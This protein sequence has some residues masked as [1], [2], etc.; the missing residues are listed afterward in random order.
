[1]DGTGCGWCPVESFITGRVRT[2]SRI[3]KNF[4]N[5]FDVSLFYCCDTRCTLL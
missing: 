1:M 3:L 5:S 4:V 2:S